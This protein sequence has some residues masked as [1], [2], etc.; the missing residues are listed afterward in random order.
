M[1]TP[2][3]STKSGLDARGVHIALGN[4]LH[5]VGTASVG[6]T[7]H[8]AGHALTTSIMVVAQDRCTRSAWSRKS[9]DSFT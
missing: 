3:G 2:E 5:Y 9:K 6:Y 1:S 4:D 8:N 7:G